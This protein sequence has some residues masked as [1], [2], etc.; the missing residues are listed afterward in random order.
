MNHTPQPLLA[1]L[2]LS[3]SASLSSSYA[4]ADSDRLF[5]EDSDDEQLIIESGDGE[6]LSIDD[7]LDGDDLIIDDELSIDDGLSTDDELSI[8]E[9]LNIDDDLNIGDEAGTDDELNLGDELGIADQPPSQADQGVSVSLDRAW[10][11]TG[12]LESDNPADYQLYGHAR[13]K[14]HWQQGPWEAQAA[15]RVDLYDEH[16]GGWDDTD[17][18]YDE[19]FIRYRS[20]SG[21][22]TLG[23][24]RVIWGRIDELPP[25]DRLSTPDLRR[26]LLDDLEDRRLASAAVRYEHFMDGGRQKLDFLYVPRLREAELPDN[27]GIWYPINQDKGTIIG[28]DTTAAIE[29][30]VR[31]AAIDDSAPDTDGGLGVRFNQ[32][33]SGYDYALSIQRG[34]ATLP[35]FTYN[36]ARNLV[37]AKHLRSTTVSGDLGFEA[38]GGT[39]KLEAAWNSDTPI[40]RTNGRFDSTESLAWGVALEMFP[41]DGDTRLN[42]QLVGNYLIDAPSV[43][44][45]D[46]AVSFNGS[47]EWPFADNNWRA[48]MRFNV[49]LDM[50]DLYFNPELTYTG[51]SSQELYLELHSYDGDKGSVGGFYEDNSLISLGWRIDL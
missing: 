6:S 35:Y 7:G 48:R 49:G 31:T 17:L 29:A 32:Q 34:V 47:L 25:S 43:L 40:T 2:L 28:L 19:T 51:F 23:A 38:L 3:L 41:G 26:G 11:E 42:L 46:K 20:K 10:F 50:N 12:F 45:R 27:R 18:D 36:P 22:L 13:A 5:I 44:D 4:N 8:D 30:V 9:D 15:A 21:I 1:A 33:G 37:E 24:Q 16:P 39:L 14:I